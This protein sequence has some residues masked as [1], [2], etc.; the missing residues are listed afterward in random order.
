[1]RKKAITYISHLL[2]LLVSFGFVFPALI[3]HKSDEGPIMAVILAIVLFIFYLPHIWRG[4][5]YLFTKIKF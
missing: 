1:M 4:V 2:V 5:L 3:S